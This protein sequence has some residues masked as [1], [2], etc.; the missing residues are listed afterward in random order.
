L[1]VSDYN[2]NAETVTDKKGNCSYRFSGRYI[3]GKKNKGNDVDAIDK[4]YIS[5]TPLQIDQT[6]F[7][8]LREMQKVN[9][10]KN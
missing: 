2:E 4:G 1:G 5:I 7:N 6:H 8:L 9:I 10:F 3:S